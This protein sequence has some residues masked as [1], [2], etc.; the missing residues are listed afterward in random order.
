MPRPCRLL[1][2]SLTLLLF[3]AHPIGARGDGRALD[4]ARVHFEAGQSLFEKGEY[5]L[6]SSAFLAAY[7]AR[8]FAAFLFNAAVAEERKGDLAKAVDLFRRYLTEDSAATDGV[9]IAA[10]IKSL[11]DRLAVPAT[12]PPPDTTPPLPQLPPLPD[13]GIKGLI[14]VETEP[15]GAMIY[16]DR[17]EPSALLGAAPWH[18]SLSGRHTL[19]VELRGHQ[20]VRRV[21][22]LSSDT[23]YVY[24]FGLKRDA[25]LGFVEIRSNIAH[26]DVFIDRKE[27]GA[28]GRTPY[29]GNLPRGLHTIWV[30]KEGYV[31]AKRTIFVQAEGAQSIPV[32]LELA[33]SGFIRI[34]GDASTEGAQVLLDGHRVAAC[35]QIPCRFEAPEGTHTLSIRKSGKKPVDRS[36]AV[37]PATEQSV[38]VKLAAKPSRSDA[39]LPILV[40]AGVATGAVFLLREADARAAAHTD[41]STPQPDEIRVFRI[42]AAVAF[43]LSGLSLAQGLYYLVRDKGPPSS[44]VV[45]TSRLS[46]APALGPGLLGLAAQGVF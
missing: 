24:S 39:I 41:P 7:A 43:G 2:S 1:V 15:A 44:A 10:R 9:E 36:L 38:A 4:E 34:G 11:E 30:R 3:L 19:I 27:D 22:D 42:G 20:Q 8:P 46:F 18:G 35:P 25:I 6:A 17:K 37:T 23:F 26:A 31:E 5:G 16:L 28:V 13:V 33:P 29:L 14:A 32:P 12:T 45:E 40:S 21:V